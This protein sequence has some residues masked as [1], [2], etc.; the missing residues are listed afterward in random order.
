LPG[1]ALVDQQEIEAVADVPD[2]SGELARQ[3][4][5]ALSRATGQQQDRVRFRV[6]CAGRYDRDVNAYR[7]ARG[8]AGGFRHRHHAA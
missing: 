3:G 4:G 1:A 2:A 6:R 8:L 5:S 7:A